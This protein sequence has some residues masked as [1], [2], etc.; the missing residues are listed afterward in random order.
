MNKSISTRVRYGLAYLQ[1]MVFTLLFSN[2]VWI[3]YVHAGPE[4]GTVTGG[5]GSISQSGSQTTINQSSQN[6]AIDWQSYNLNS[7]ERVHYIQPN[8]SSISLNRILSNNGSQIHGRIDANGQVILINPHGI[9]IGPTA[10]INVGG[11]V[12]SSLD[13]N[14]TDFMNG[15]YIFNEVLGTDGKVVNAGIINASVGGNVALIGKQVQNDGL[16]AA[17]LG[18][19]ALAAGKEAVLTFD[20]DGLVGVKI[21]KA[22]LQDEIGIDPAVLNSGTI[23]AEGGRVLLTAS[24]SQDVFSQA[25]NTSGMEPATSVVVHPDGTFSLGG[26]ADV[27]NTGSIDVSKTDSTGAADPNTARIILIGENVT[28]SGTLKADNANGDGGEIELHAKNITL[29][30]ENSLTSARSETNGKGGIIKILGDKVGLFDQSTVDVSGDDGGGQAL[31]GGDFQGNNP[32]IRNSTETI[33]NRD[34]SIYADALTNGDGGKVI[35]WSDGNTFFGG[36]I[37]TRG[38]SES[39]D[40]GLVETSGK[41]NLLFRGNTDRTAANGNT[42]TLLLDPANIIIGSATDDD[43]RLDDRIVSFGEGGGSDFDISATKLVEELV[44]GS[45]I[46]Q[47]NRDIRVESDVIAGS[48]NTSSLTM[49]AGDDI[50]MAKQIILSLWI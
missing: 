32:F 7:N 10:S 29:L 50:R 5:S 1:A 34:T 49:H 16:I 31:I 27:V 39:G 23:N 35:L 3:P 18:S 42:G 20:N 19:V 48:G 6:M 22:I 9:F 37:Y 43:S 2:I 14:P 28:S 30:T 24:V 46:L 33:V 44:N 21:T 41:E 12:A 13:M 26:G 45:V 25:V 15:N 17:K 40:G 11:I 8:S 36:N 4:G 38:G 47:A